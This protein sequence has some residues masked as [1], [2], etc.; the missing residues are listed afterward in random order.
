MR[1]TITSAVS[2]LAAIAAVLMMCSAPAMAQNTSSAI[3]GRI[4]GGEG[5]PLAGAVVTVVHNESGSV[6]KLVTDAEGRYG[7]RGLR[8]G[9]PYTVT[10]S[11]DGKVEKREDVFLPL[12]ETLNLDV[13][14]GA[15]VQKV[16]VSGAANAKIFNSAAMGTG[17]SI[18]HVELESYASIRRNLQDYARMDPRL[19]QTDKERGEISAAG[20][21]TRYNLVTIDGVAIND[22]FGLEA[23]NLPT[24]KQPISM[25]AIDSVQVNVANYDVTQKG[26]TGANINAITKSGTNELKGSVY[27]VYRGDSW[28][29]DRYNRTNDSYFPFLPFKEDT[30]GATLGG[31][32][33][34]DKLF[35]FAN[36][37]EFKSNRAQPEFGPVGSN[38]TN[39]AISQSSIDALK[40][41]AKNQYKLD[42]GDPIGPSLLTVK[43][44]LFK[45]N[46]NINDQ[47][48]ASLRLTRTEQNETNFGNFSATGLN[49]TS[50]WWN[51]QKAIDTVVA[52]WFADWTPNFSTEMKVSKRDY[53]SVPQ[54]NSNLPAMAL[55]FSGPAPAGAPA[56]VNTG[57][58]F[59]NFGTELSRHFNVL[60]TKTVDAY[61]GAT[62]A[63]DKHEL[64][65]GADLQDNKVYNA[66]FQNVKGNYTFSCQNSSA[67]YLYSFGTINCGTATA[68]QIE[69]AVL[70][71]FA[72]GRPSSYQVQVPVAGGTLD[73]G[74]AK[75]SLADTGV[76]VQ[77]TWAVN[78]KL[79]ITGGVRLDTL[80]TD[81]KPAFNAAAAAPLVAGSVNGN[82]VVRNSGGFG[83]DNSITV[84]GKNLLQPRVG[85][86][87]RLDPNVDKKQQVRG[88][89]GLFQGAAANVWLSNPYS[90]TGLATRV[91]GCGGSFPACPTAGGIFSTDPNNQPTNFTGT[92]PAANVDFIDKNLNQPAVWKM[93]LA[94]DT[95]LPWGGLVFGAEFLHTKTDTGIYYKHL[96]LGGATRIGPDGREL[97]YTPQAYNPACWTATGG[98]I[99]TGACAGLRSRALSNASFNN[100]LITA[101]TSQ[102][103]GNVLTLSLSSPTKR[104]FG[105][106]AAYTRTAATEVS[107]LTSS[108]SV[109]NFNARSVFN[110]NEE[111]AANS[112]YL[113]KDRVSAAINWS[114]AFVDNYKT[115]FGLFYEGRSGK[116]YSWTYRND[117]NGDS[118]SGNDLMYIPSAPQSGEVAFLGDT[119]TSH[120]NE[121]RF[122]SIVNQN[123]ALSDAK[124][125]VVKRNSAFS[126]WVNSF[127]MRISQQVPGFKPKHG[128]LLVFDIFNIGNLLNKKW[129]RINEMA[130]QSSGG[131]T[132]R[133]VNVVGINAQGKY[134][135]QVSPAVDD[136]T[137]RQ[138]SGE[139]QWALQVTLKYEF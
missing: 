50:W 128:G 135:Y 40:T 47:H 61:F 35:F 11:K 22:T 42:V 111:V 15:E 99:T 66:F 30:K 129:G 137:L 13:S 17:T 8:V 119:A 123:K 31:P 1:S 72:K 127:D 37:E 76:F 106:Q 63:L 136:L 59:L 52:Q 25:E 29:G 48:R 96:N 28:V 82:T 73:N 133:F 71:N 131:Q 33:I 100:V 108:V 122:W 54:N 5:K 65:F 32:I 2:R 64:K 88:G 14:L 112:A 23:N 117:I 91:I 130:F 125:G 74:I 90:N 26:Y 34:Q 126:P 97:Y 67:T 92:P 109:S 3:A 57:N 49:L 75:W 68:A 115:T 19:S 101:P 53:N 10:I 38:L 77:D 58:R 55:Q 39:V 102:G 105:W 7:A 81:D 18:G 84:D 120:T 46:W 138:V 79:S 118:V 95:E 43:D 114:R 139:S 6:S 89:I 41:L 4:T 80:S 124:G 20:Q 93:N 16:V 9:G 107:P 116:P 45:L 85:F 104:G 60:D 24:A 103:T 94:Y 86:N 27:Y 12:A 121:D 132:R 134:V 83:L 21:N 98:A 62:W 78:D 36:Y 110:P 69:A 70:E 87:Y 56:G 44:A 51:Q 113:V